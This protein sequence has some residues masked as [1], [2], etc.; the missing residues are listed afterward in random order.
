MGGVLDDL[1]IYNIYPFN[2]KEESLEIP[3]AEIPN[4]RHMKPKIES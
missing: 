2:N 1:A 3:A 4:I